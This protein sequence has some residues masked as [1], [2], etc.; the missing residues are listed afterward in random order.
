M[1]I[2]EAE[3]SKKLQ[4]LINTKNIMQH[5]QIHKDGCVHQNG[6]SE[7]ETGYNNGITGITKEINSELKNPDCGRKSL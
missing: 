1:L 2:N 3:V 5:Y 7:H 4:T 6:V